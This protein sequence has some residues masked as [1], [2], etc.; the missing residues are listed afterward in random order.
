M[1]EYS[2]I[3]WAERRGEKSIAMH[4]NTENQFHPEA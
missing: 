3:P 4:Y 2:I 1:I